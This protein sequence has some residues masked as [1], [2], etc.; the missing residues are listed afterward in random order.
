MR[1]GGGARG[2][3]GERCTGARRTL[4]D[5]S[6]VAGETS[7]MAGGDRGPATESKIV[8]SWRM[9]RSWSWPIVAKDAAGEGLSR[10]LIKSRAACWA[11]LEEDVWGMAQLW[12]KYSTA[13]GM[14]RCTSRQRRDWPRCGGRPGFHGIGHAYRVVQ[15]ASN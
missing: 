4:G 1:C 5:G 2:A 9:A 15:G 6:R 13:Q 14:R 7:G 8:A 11:L 10:T 3:E 12:G